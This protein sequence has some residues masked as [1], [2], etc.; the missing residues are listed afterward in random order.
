MGWGGGGNND[1]PYDGLH[2]EALPEGDTFLSLP[3]GGIENGRDFM[4][5]SINKGRE[6]CQ[7]CLKQMHQNEM[8]C[9]YDRNVKG[10]TIFCGRYMYMKGYLFGQ[11]WF[12]KG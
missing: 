8:Q 11:K 7:N 3:C 1:S 12:I 5:C 10:G 9:S 6:N 4:T 2:W